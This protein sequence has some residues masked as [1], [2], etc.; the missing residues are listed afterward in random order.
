MF[1]VIA[2]LGAH[3]GPEVFKTHFDSLFFL[4]LTDA[5]ANVRE[6]AAKYLDVKL[7]YYKIVFL[8]KIW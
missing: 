3:F 1:E 8:P 6:S 4:Y 5:V 2:K 7:N